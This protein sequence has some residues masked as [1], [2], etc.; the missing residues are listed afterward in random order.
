MQVAQCSQGFPICGCCSVLHILAV[1]CRKNA[2]DMIAEAGAPAPRSA[3]DSP[4]YSACQPSSRTIVRSASRVPWYS[5]STPC[6]PSWTAPAQDHSL[7]C[8]KACRAARGLKTHSQLRACFHRQ[9]RCWHQGSPCKRVFITSSG[10][11]AS[12][13]VRPALQPATACFLSVRNCSSARA[14]GTVCITVQHIHDL[15]RHRAVTGMGVDSAGHTTAVHLCWT[16]R[17]IGTLFWHTAGAA[18]TLPLQL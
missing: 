10:C 12:T 6:M 16:W 8:S 3:G 17:V 9:N 2:N 11:R 7:N 13:E 18:L 15:V 1:T 14:S 4:A 5:G